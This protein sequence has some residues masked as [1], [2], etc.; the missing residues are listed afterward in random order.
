MRFLLLVQS[1]ASLTKYRPLF[2]ARSKDPPGFRV[3]A[4]SNCNQVSIGGFG[5]IWFA[6][7]GP[8]SRQHLK[9]KIT[10]QGL[11]IGDTTRHGNTFG[12][13]V[14]PGTSFLRNDKCIGFELDLIN[15]LQIKVYR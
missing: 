3:S 15:E 12:N 14:K 4:N 2:I 7:P 13:A 1:W 8:V 9:Y 11:W 10:L 5:G 6:K